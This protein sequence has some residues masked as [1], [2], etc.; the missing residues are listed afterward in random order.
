MNVEQIGFI[1]EPLNSHIKLTS[2][3]KE[4]DERVLFSS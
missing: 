3:L 4:E 1:E 2:I